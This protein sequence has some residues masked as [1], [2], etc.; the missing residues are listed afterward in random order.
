MARSKITDTSTSLANDDGSVLIPI[1][2]GEQLKFEVAIN[3]LASL[4][5]YN[6]HGNLVEGVNAG[7]IKPTTAKTGGVRRLL[8]LDNGLITYPGSGNTFTFTIP[9]DLAITASPKP[10]PEESIFFFIDIEV[11]EPGTGDTISPIGDSAA[12]TKQV[13]KPIRGLVEVL[14]S[15]TEEI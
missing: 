9:Y 10:S 5:S 6:I 4:V 2:N 7:G 14:Y 15:P 8:S 3:W 13:W 11:G 1:V 12:V